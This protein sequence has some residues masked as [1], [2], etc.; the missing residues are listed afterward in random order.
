MKSNTALLFAGDTCILL[1]ADIVY[2]L[3]DN[4]NEEVKRL[5]MVLFAKLA[6]NVR[7]TKYVV[8]RTCSNSLALEDLLLLINEITLDEV[9]F[10]I[11]ACYLITCTG[12][13]M[14]CTLTSMT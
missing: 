2:G 10:N 7:K 14:L 5:K 11:A 8:F 4:G 1:K 12:E 3:E 9:H 6:I 13:R